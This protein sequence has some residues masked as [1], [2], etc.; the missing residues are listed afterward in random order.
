MLLN[1][2]PFMRN[3]TDVEQSMGFKFFM[4]YVVEN[5]HGKKFEIND[6]CLLA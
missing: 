3:S 2:V 5:F 6:S 1:R 4:G